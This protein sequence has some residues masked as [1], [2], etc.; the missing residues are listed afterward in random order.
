MTAAIILALLQVADALTTLKA[1]G[2]GGGE[3]NPLMR[4][5]FERFGVK[6]V[7][8]VKGVAVAAAGFWLGDSVI[9][10]ALVVF[11]FLVVANNV[12]VIRKLKKEP[13]DWH[14]V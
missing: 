11:Y 4:S 14:P 3:L 8:I 5:L 9:T 13:I 6:P 7:L 12:R 1:L 10:W 2:Y